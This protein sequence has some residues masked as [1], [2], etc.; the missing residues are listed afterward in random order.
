MHQCGRTI[1]RLD[2]GSFVL[3]VSITQRGDETVP[4][5]YVFELVLVVGKLWTYARQHTN[6]L[7][8]NLA[9]HHDLVA[10]LVLIVLPNAQRVDPDIAVRIA[11]S[12]LAQSVMAIRCDRML[13]AID[14]DGSSISILTPCV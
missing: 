8:V 6:C 3:F 5:R 9:H 14:H 11:A 13:S 12:C 1:D 7:C 2:N 10:F 4:L